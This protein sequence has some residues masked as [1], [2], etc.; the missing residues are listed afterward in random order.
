MS[1]LQGTRLQPERT[2]DH[3]VTIRA[4]EASHSR[5]LFFLSSISVQFSQREAADWD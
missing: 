2:A 1:A 4:R 3:C 5:E